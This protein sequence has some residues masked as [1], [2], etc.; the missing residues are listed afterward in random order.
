MLERQGEKVSAKSQL[1]SRAKKQRA[2][3]LRGQ[4][5]R[6]H[7]R[8]AESPKNKKVE[9]LKQGLR[10]LGA[11]GPRCQWREKKPLEFCVNCPKLTPKTSA[12]GN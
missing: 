4:G 2:E 9:G 7:D 11:K 10:D 12:P 3:G 8:G 1:G 6:A 5:S